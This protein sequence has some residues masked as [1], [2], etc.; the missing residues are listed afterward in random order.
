MESFQ[1][2]S[3]FPESFAF[4]FRVLYYSGLL[5]VSNATVRQKLSW[6]ASGFT[7]L[8][9]GILVTISVLLAQTRSE[10]SERV[11]HFVSTLVLI[12]KIAGFKCN[13]KSIVKVT[14]KILEIQRMRGIGIF[15]KI[16]ET[17]QNFQKKNLIITI[18]FIFSASCLNIVTLRQFFFDMRVL[19]TNEDLLLLSSLIETFVIS[20]CAVVYVTVDNITYGLFLFLEAHLDCLR[21]EIRQ[22][23]NETPEMPLNIKRLKDIVRYH[24]DILRY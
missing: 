13:E 11:A 2:I 3:K 20:Y 19:T 4:N 10:V 5:K 24:N 14:T 18:L 9:V 1:D 12:I 6:C 16:D 8:V 21:E 23:L 17:C 15:T 22:L 7:L